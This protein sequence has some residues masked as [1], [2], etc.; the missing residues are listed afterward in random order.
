MSD[1]FDSPIKSGKVR[2]HVYYHKYR[3]GVITINGE[4][5]LLYTI[6][7]AVR[8]WRKKNPAFKK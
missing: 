6:T 1:L 4:K 3:N 8:L 7:E 5:Y 2:N